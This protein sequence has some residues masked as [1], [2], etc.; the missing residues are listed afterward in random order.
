MDARRSWVSRPR[1][2][3]TADGLAPFNGLGASASPAPLR[4]A[5]R[6]LASEPDFFRAPHEAIA[7]LR[8]RVDA[9]RRRLARD[10]EIGCSL[11]ERLRSWARLADGAVTGLSQLARVCVDGKARSTVAPFAFIAV[12]KYGARCCDPDTIL[13]LQCLLPEDQESWE[14]GGRIVAFLRIGLAELGLEHHDAMGTAVECARVARGDAIAAA[15]FATARFL[16]G[17]YG[18]HAGFVMLRRAAAPPRAVN[19]SIGIRRRR[20]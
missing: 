7:R 12:G 16:S 17:Q 4:H 20:T 11:D 18:L 6:A 8:P 19:T 5:L 9:E 15:R 13:E 3:Q 14:R 1:D 10:L 2:S